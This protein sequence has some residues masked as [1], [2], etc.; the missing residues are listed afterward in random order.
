MLRLSLL[1][2][3][4]LAEQLVEADDLFAFAGPALEKHRIGLFDGLIAIDSLFLSA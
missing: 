4:L 3:A 1:L 2:F